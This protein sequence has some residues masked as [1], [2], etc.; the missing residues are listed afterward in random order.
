MIFRT[1][2]EIPKF[3]FRISHSDTCVFSGSCFAENIGTKLV[4]NKFS[5][6]V[7]PTGIHYNPISLAESVLMAISLKQISENDVFK[8]NSLFNHFNF[9]SKF[10]DID[11]TKAI[12]N[13]NSSLE[14]FKQTLIKSKYFFVTFGTS[15]VY[16]LKENYKIVSNCHKLPEKLFVREFLSL[17]E[18]TDTW[19]KLIQ[20]LREINPEIKFIFSISPIRHLKDGGIENQQ[21]KS[22]LILS[23]KNI[24]EETICSF[25]FPAYEIM[26]DELRDYRFYADDM[27]HP[28]K[29]AIDY[30][31]EKFANSFFSQASKNL[32]TQI[33]KINLAYNHKIFNPNSEAHKNFCL[34]I[35][36]TINKVKNQYS[37]LDFTNEIRHFESFLK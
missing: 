29:L 1:L 30:I 12:N 19:I 33:E 18:I 15:F 6:S 37:F 32:N 7:N 21:S 4:L 23:V 34:N 36:K 5:A 8:A 27:I 25:Y 13:F 31:Y 10:S 11:K 28:S 22:N 16:K 2:I 3:D 17:Q 14:N 24:I 35:L 9:H 26:N 20:K